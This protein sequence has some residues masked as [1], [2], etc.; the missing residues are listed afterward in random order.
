MASSKLGRTSEAEISVAAL[1][2][3]A[4]RPGGE[5]S[6]DTLKELMP[7]YIELTEGDLKQSPT[8]R[9]EQM[10]HQIVGN[11]VSHRESEGNIIYDGYATYTGNGIKITDKGRAY[12]RGK[13]YSA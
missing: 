10:F 12:L 9:N 5:A 2:I 1:R 13:G 7:D 8:R 11:I 3:A 6:T 4:N